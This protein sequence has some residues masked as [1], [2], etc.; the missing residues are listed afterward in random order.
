ME[1][2]PLAILF[3][4]IIIAVYSYPSLPEK[5]PV[6]WN[7][8]GEIDG[9]SSKEFVF[10]IP[11]I[12]LIFYVISLFL[13]AMDTYSDNIKKFYNY[14][15]LM[16]VGLGVFFLALFIITLLPNYNYAVDVSKTVMILISLLF[17]LLGHIMGKTKR[18]YFIG[19]RT[20]WTLSS[21]DV[22]KKTHALGGKLF[23][24]FGALTLIMSFFLKPEISYSILVIG[25]ILISIFVIIYSY[26]IYKQ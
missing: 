21:E 13:P 18:N 25:V 9:F 8:Q 16:K 7:A 15:Y 6:H 17:V 1:I 10:L 12:Y 3:L 20:A 22:W 26:K 19:I 2:I 14:Y 24:T 5:I 11:G 23:M 4:M